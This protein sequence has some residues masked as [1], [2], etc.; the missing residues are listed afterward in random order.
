MDRIGTYHIKPF[1]TQ[2]K[3]VTLIIK[4]GWKKHTIHTLIEIDV[5]NARKK[6]RNY[7]E[8]TGEKLS[9][10]GWII[11]CAAKALSDHKELNAIRKGRNKIIYF[12][13]VDIPIPVERTMDNEKIPMAYILRKANE[14]TLLEIT[15]EIRAV[16]KQDVAGSKQVLGSEFT[17]L[18]KI[19]FKSPMILKKLLLFFVQRSPLLKKKH[20]GTLGVTAVGMKG[21]LPGWIIPLGG[22]TTILFVIGGITKKPGVIENDTIAIR[23]YLHLTIAV[24]HDLIDGGPLARFLAR[25]LDLCDKGYGIPIQNKKE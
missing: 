1:S 8:Q 24:D 22:T 16:Q 11:T 17:L 18:E 14:K 25:F 2:R 15:K 9:F 7:A 10:T 6:I 12:D 13:D 3:N 20:M 19:A 4:E 21:S 23:D 5:T